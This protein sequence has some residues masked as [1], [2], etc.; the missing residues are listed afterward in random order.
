MANLGVTTTARAVDRRKKK[1]SDSHGKY[2]ENAFVKY[3][4]KAFVLNVDDY[5]NIHVQRRP[6][7]IST[8]WAA[9]MAT[10]I[11]NS[12]ST[13]A[14]LHNGV[15]NPKIVDNELIEKH[16]DERFIINLRISYHNRIRMRDYAGYECSDDELIDRL[17]LHSYNDRLAEKK[18]ERHI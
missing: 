12:C 3:S 14:I 7:T 4:E 10:I 16:L 8:S 18:G 11:A 1:T 6:D 9:H 5:H 2:V 17:T 15:I 13:L